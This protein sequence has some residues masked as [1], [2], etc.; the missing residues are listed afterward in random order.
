MLAA[1]GGVAKVR[2]SLPRG[3]KEAEAEGSWALEHSRAQ[4]GGLP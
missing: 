3:S 1:E 2:H 4:E